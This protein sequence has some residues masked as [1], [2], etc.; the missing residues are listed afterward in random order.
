VRALTPYE[1]NPEAPRLLE[2]LSG[3]KDTP[4]PSSILTTSKT[5]DSPSKSGKKR[6]QF[7]DDVVMHSPPD[8]SNS[9]KGSPE[10]S[11]F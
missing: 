2:Q 11:V 10:V 9:K 1:E 6:V 4:K 5:G 7:S 8:K 3:R